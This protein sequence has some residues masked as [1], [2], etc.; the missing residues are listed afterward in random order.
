ML[1]ITPKYP[2]D[3]QQLMSSEATPTLTGVLPVFQGLQNHWQ[4]LLTTTMPTMKRYILQGM[5]WLNKY[6]KKAGKTLVY[7]MAMGVLFHY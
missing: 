7:A 6:H 2:H 3:V 1:I 4:E 5:E